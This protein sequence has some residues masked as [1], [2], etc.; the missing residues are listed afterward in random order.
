MGRNKYHKKGE[1]GTMAASGKGTASQNGKEMS[2][3]LYAP[4]LGSVFQ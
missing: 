3:S 2:L 1:L 4:V